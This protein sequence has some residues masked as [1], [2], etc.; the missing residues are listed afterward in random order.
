MNGGGRERVVLGFGE[1]TLAIENTH[2]AT[3]ID[4]CKHGLRRGKR[5][6]GCRSKKGRRGRRRK[7]ARKIGSRDRRKKRVGEEIGGGGG[8]G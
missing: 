4:A 7:R 1:E 6:T 3:L 5:K 8:E 2:S